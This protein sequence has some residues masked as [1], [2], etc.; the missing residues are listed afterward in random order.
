MGGHVSRALAESGPTLACILPSQTLPKHPDISQQCPL[1]LRAI[2][3]WLEAGA[4]PG[5]EFDPKSMHHLLWVLT[6]LLYRYW[7]K[8]RHLVA[9][10]AWPFEQDP[11]TQSTSPCCFTHSLKRVRSK[12]RVK[13]RSMG[14]KWI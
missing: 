9:D 5:Q 14:Y 11:G 2:M 6:H 8:T 4:C 12:P 3:S 10:C 1:T 7:N 13:C